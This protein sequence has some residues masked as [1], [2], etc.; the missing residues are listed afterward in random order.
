MDKKF[1]EMEGL[2]RGQL[3]DL[4]A[5]TE[6]VGEDDG[7]RAGGLNCGQQALVGDGFGD[8]EFAGFEAEGAGHSA[9]AS[10]D[11]L[12]CGAG[13]AEQRDFAG[14]TAEDGLVMAVAVNEDV[15][16]LK[17]AGGKFGRA[18]SEPVRE[19]PDLPAQ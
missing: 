6:T 15:R 3:R 1:G 13:F 16:A 17:A 5:A 4:L 12:D 10:L 8:L 19:Q 18:I 2:A 11:G 7:G 9:A 14:R